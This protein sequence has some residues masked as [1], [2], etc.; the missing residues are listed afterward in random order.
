MALASN[1][2]DKVLVWQM[3]LLKLLSHCQ[4]LVRDGIFAIPATGN[5]VRLRTF[6][7]TGMRPYRQGDGL[8]CLAPFNEPTLKPILC[9]IHYVFS[10]VVCVGVNRRNRIS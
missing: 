1:R 4:H 10:F 9:V 6:E 2:E 3:S 5:A 8:R 7:G